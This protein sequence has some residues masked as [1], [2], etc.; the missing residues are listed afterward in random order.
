MKF[1]RQKAKPIEHVSEAQL[2]QGLGYMHGISG[3]RFAILN[4]DDRSYVQAG[5]SGMT[6]CLEW[7]DMK[8]RRH[9]RAFQH[10]PIVPWPGITRLRISEG[11]VS[12]HQDEYFRITQVT[13]AFL[14]FFHR[15]PFPEYVQWRD[16]TDELIAKGCSEFE[17]SGGRTG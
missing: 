8:R 6:C 2:N 4:D 1:E 15:Q 13:E 5:G 7:R 9:F 11:E 3:C 17:D 14:A 12:L 10:P 16:V